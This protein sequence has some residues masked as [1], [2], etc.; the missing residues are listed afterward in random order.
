MLISS[1]LG[2]PAPSAKQYNRKILQTPRIR[3]KLWLFIKF[4]SFL[5]KSKRNKWKLTRLSF[6]TSKPMSY[7]QVIH[8]ALRA[9]ETFT[10]LIMVCLKRYQ[11]ISPE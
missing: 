8:L 9:H 5:R 4:K 2:F 6:F 10:K 11:Q 3:F 1:I 7:K